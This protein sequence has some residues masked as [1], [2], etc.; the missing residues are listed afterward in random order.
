MLLYAPYFSPQNNWS[1]QFSFV[2]EGADFVLPAPADSEAFYSSLMD[3]A[4]DGR[5]MV[6]YENDFMSCLAMTDTFRSTVGAG[7]QWLVGQSKAAQARGIGV[8]YCMT[9]PS[10]VLASVEAPMV[11]NGR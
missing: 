6:G 1:K 8:Q 3:F 11:T 10:Q 2:P 9:F 5:G 4:T 7:R